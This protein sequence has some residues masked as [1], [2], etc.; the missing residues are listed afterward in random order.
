MLANSSINPVYTDV[1]W[2][3]NIYEQGIMEQVYFWHSISL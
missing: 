1:L 3:F 2:L